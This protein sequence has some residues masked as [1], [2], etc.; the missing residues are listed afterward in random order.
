[1]A[2]LKLEDI[3]K[4]PPDQRVK[5]LKELEE[6]KKKEITELEQKILKSVDEAKKEEDRRI[7]LFKEE[8]Q[9]V[10][11]EELAQVPL[12]ETVQK[13]EAPPLPPGL[14]Q[15][16]GPKLE[17]AIDT[18]RLYE[19]AKAL[20]QKAAAGEIGP[21]DEGTASYLRQQIEVAKQQEV[22]ASEP[23]QQRGHLIIIAEDFLKKAE[24]KI[25]KQE[26][27]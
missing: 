15:Y 16:G 26:T 24:Y 17:K 18:G 3:E 8:R 9:A 5:K 20:E 22:K 6:Q 14:I 2:E 27:Y 4:L 25:R 12:E 13:T 11:E 10:T 19:T 1:M 7:R 21:G 23:S